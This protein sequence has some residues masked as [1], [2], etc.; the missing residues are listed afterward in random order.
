LPY[1]SE[2][3]RVHRHFARWS[4][5]LLHLARRPALRRPAFGLLARQAWALERLV[6]WASS[7]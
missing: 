1:E 5:P 2:A 3:Q 4:I 6:G 7:P